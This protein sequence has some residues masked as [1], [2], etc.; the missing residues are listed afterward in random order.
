M[1][2]VREMMIRMSNRPI[3]GYGVEGKATQGRLKYDPRPG[4]RP[5]PAE[6]LKDAGEHGPA[7][8]ED[9]DAVRE[10][11][12]LRLLESGHF[13][14]QP[15]DLVHDPADE[16][17]PDEPERFREHAGSVDVRAPGL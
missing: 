16:Q 12:E 13:P 15:V 1:V 9:Q 3:A 8:A 10:I 7:A 4:S 6:Q 14:P 17:E 11:V 5:K 2:T